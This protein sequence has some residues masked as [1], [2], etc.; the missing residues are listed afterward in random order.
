MIKKLLVVITLVAVVAACGDKKKDNTEAQKFVCVDALNEDADALLALDEVTLVGKLAKCP[1][2][3]DG[4]V[5]VGKGA[6]IGIVPAEGVEVDKTLLCNAVSVTGKLSVTEWDADAIAALEAKCAEA[7]A[8]CT[9]HAEENPA[10][11]E[12]KKCCAE[13]EK[14]G[15]TCCSAGKE[16]GKTCCSAPKVGDKFYVLTVTKIEKFECPD[17]EKCC[18]GKEGEKCCKGKEGEKACGEKKAC[19]EEK[20]ACEGK[21]AEPEQKTEE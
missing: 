4:V 6:F 12:T 1:I 19:C 11:E 2:T 15:K 13:K 9:K 17:K 7:K 20:K 14:E 16:E 5:L 8:A 21:T 18:K 10:T 3:D